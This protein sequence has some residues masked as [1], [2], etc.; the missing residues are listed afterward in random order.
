MN[1]H[2]QKAQ[3]S[4]VLCFLRTGRLNVGRLKRRKRVSVLNRDENRPNKC[5][6]KI[7]F[8]HFE[9]FERFW[10]FHTKSK[11]IYTTTTAEGSGKYVIGTLNAHVF[12]CEKNI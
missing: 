10:H 2:S 6:R 11:R 5:G 12:F 4:R 8:R 3:Y 9:I 1:R 7:F